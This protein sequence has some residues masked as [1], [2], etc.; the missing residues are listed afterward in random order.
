[1]GS[2]KPNEKIIEIFEFPLVAFL[3]A[4]GIPIKSAFPLPM[5]QEGNRILVGFEVIETPEVNRIISNYHT[6]GLVP[7]KSLFEANKKIK[8]TA[9]AIVRRMRY[10]SSAAVRMDL[11]R[12]SSIPEKK[13]YHRT[14]DVSENNTRS[15]DSTESRT[16]KATS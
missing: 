1:M 7:V 6:N 16:R 12:T 4:S 3:L 2:E 15:L 5:S 13:Y 11:R 8:D 14:G 9:M 10:S